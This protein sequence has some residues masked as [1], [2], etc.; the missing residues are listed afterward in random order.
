MDWFSFLVG[1]LAC[2]ILGLFVGIVMGSLSAQV[3]RGRDDHPLIS[4]REQV[5]YGVLSQ[6]EEGEAYHFS[7]TAS[8]MGDD[9]DDGDDEEEDVPEVPLVESWRNN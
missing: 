1:G 8:K 9:E 3:I 6:L 4:M 2:G 5:V 7:F